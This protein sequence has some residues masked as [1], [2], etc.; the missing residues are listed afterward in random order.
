MRTP[1]HPGEILKEEMEFINISANKLAN[2]L[3]VPTNRITQIINKKRAITPDTARRLGAFFKTSPQFWMNLQF[4][5]EMDLD[6]SDT[7]KE[8]EIASIKPYVESAVRAI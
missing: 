6:F 1:I 2:N 8:K 7:A 3:N 5:Y 4:I